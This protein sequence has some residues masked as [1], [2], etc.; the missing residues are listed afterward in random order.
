MIYVPADV[1]TADNI[2]VGTT[3]PCTFYPTVH[4]V[5]KLFCDRGTKRWS[6]DSVVNLINLHNDKD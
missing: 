6:L 2:A 4:S 1:G 3:A 5:K